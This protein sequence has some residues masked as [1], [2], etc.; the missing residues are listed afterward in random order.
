[1][2]KLHAIFAFLQ[3]LMMDPIANVA[4]D[5]KN[6]DFLNLACMLQKNRASG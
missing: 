2:Q 3:T 5:L 6:H 1:M 4:N